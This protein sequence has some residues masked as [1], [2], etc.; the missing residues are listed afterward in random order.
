MSKRMMS[1]LSMLVVLTLL[2]GACGGES[3]TPTPAPAAVLAKI[4]RPRF[5]RLKCRRPPKRRSPL[6]RSP[7]RS[8]LPPSSATLLRISLTAG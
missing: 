8:I 2:L 5:R 6:R 4:R 7:K 3:A 1:I